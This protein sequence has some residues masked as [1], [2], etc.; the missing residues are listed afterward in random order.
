MSSSDAHK[1]DGAAPTSPRPA[2]GGP[3]TARASAA[4]PAALSPP[5]NALALLKALKRRWLVA[6]LLGVLAAAAVGAAVWFFLPPA[7]YTA[8]ARLEM[9]SK[10]EGLVYDHP[11]AKTDFATF[12]PKQVGLLK[13][14]LVLNTALR[15]P[16][17]AQLKEV[18]EH[19]D[20]VDWLEKEVHVDFP[21]G[22]ELARVT[23]S[24]DDPEA[25]KALV[26][27]VV[28]AY[29]REIVN[30]A[31]K[32][33]SAKLEEL[34]QKCKQYDDKVTKLRATVRAKAEA[35]GSSDNQVLA[36]RQRMAHEKAEKLHGDLLRSESELTALENAEELIKDRDP[37]K[38]EV[39]SRPVDLLVDKERDVALLI[40][41]KADLE[42]TLTSTKAR[43][44]DGEKTGTPGYRAV[45][46]VI[47]EL[48]GVKKD[49]EAKR[50]ALRPE[51]VKQLQGQFIQ[52]A[53]L[54]AVL[55]HDKVVEVRSLCKR[56]TSD[57][58]RLEGEAKEINKT[59][60]DL[61]DKRREIADAEAVAAK[62]ALEMQKLDVE[63]LDPARVTLMEEAVVTHPD[64][65]VRKLQAAAA[66]AGGALLLVLLLVGFLEFRARRVVS[67]EDVAQGL[68][69]KLVGTVPARRLGA[70]DA[71]WQSLL[72]ES[73][74]STR[75]MLVHSAQAGGVRVVMI[76]S[77]VGGEGKTSLASHLAVSLARG[78]RKTLLLDAD[79]RNPAAHRLFERPLGPGFSELLRGEAPLPDVLQATA[80]PGLHL[81]AAGRCD[82]ATPPLLGQD[83]PARAFA[84]LKEQFDF[85]IV[86]SSPVLPVADSLLLAQ[87]VDGVLFSVM[88]NVS[89]L[90]TVHRARQ[91]L[92]T[93]D[94]VLLGA[95]VNAA[96][97]EA[98]RYGRR[99]YAATLPSA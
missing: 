73:V 46:K 22:P 68:G 10:P 3:G 52:E 28:N 78:G 70:P 20:P 82:R 13:S 96:R 27:A 64:E 21:N 24:S 42:D 99:Q 15:D 65:A 86:D 59:A 77:A 61:E 85:I 49:L 38:V 32:G 90:P 31:T 23:V 84:R 89:T 54:K 33:R 43:V 57:I 94:V 75:A 92:A 19:P 97:E 91:R 71:Q 55:L 56:L 25:C 98:A 41:K 58:E 53:T 44:V 39:P 45:Q 67:S 35:V 72:A 80:V 2:P 60:L 79:L 1:P 26:D 88:R 48:E 66:S 34:K 36:I 29:M 7:K 93:L 51:I 6:A 62:S 40:E 12:Q 17:V 50:A 5:L 8:S 69:L 81:M 37:S 87:H 14:Q 18:K 4:A 11:E 9:K 95:V 76:T 30:V 63:L 47:V 83:V 16:K 74:D